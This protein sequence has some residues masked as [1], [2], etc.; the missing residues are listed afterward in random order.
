MTNKVYSFSGFLAS[1]LFY[2]AFL[3]LNLNFSEE[4]KEL[5][6]DSAISIMS[7]NIEDFEFQNSLKILY[8]II[9]SLCL[10]QSITL[11]I[12]S[13]KNKT[14][15]I[16]LIISAILIISCG[17]IS[18]SQE[19]FENT[20]LLLWV[21]VLR[22]III[23][24]CLQIAFILFFAKDKELFKKSTKFALISISILTIISGFIQVNVSGIIQLQFSFLSWVL[25]FLGF[26][27]ISIDQLIEKTKSS[28]V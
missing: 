7:F 17:L 8:I 3:F 15:P 27:I 4:T 16:L 6:V 28:H 20:F 1:I 26:I 5:I 9:G 22:P 25:Y 19:T 14:S 21:G 23:L 24:G 11:F 2:S 10:I 13:K 18:A 12:K